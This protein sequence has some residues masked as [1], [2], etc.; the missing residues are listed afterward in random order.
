MT[1]GRTA[2]EGKLCTPS[3]RRRQLPASPP[4]LPHSHRFFPWPVRCTGKLCLPSMFW[5]SSGGQAETGR[6]E[7]RRHT[8]QET[9]LGSS[10]RLGRPEHLPAACLVARLP[11]VRADW[12][13]PA[14]ALRPAGPLLHKFYPVLEVCCTV[15]VS[16][17]GTGVSWGGAGV[18]DT[19]ALRQNSSGGVGRASNSLDHLGGRPTACTR[20]QLLPLSRKPITG[21]WALTVLLL[22]S[23]SWPREIVKLLLFIKF[24][25]H[26][27]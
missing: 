20:L 25:I 18:W 22:T 4:S 14:R 7:T 16:H 5:R 9:K 6:G 1:G 10:P 24:V 23:V 8:A 15:H 27:R 17:G 2:D 12:T 13:P 19:T 21:T 26:K 11:L 3:G